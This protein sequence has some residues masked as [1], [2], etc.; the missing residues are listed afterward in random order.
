MRKSSVELVKHLSIHTYVYYT[1]IH[2]YIILY[3]RI[4][5]IHIRTY[6][7][8]YIRTYITIEWQMNLFSYYI[9]PTFLAGI[10]MSRTVKVEMPST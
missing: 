3:I 5:I 2:T 9:V 6:I 4:Y 7:I 1:I 8:L 10:P